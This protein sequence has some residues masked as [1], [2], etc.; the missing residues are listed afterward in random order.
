MGTARQRPPGEGESLRTVIIALLAN[1]GIAA[2]KF[3]AALLTRSSAML[4][5]A[6]H[7][8]ADTGNQVLLLLA[9]RLARRPADEAHPLGHGREAYFWALVAAL[10]MFLTGALLAVR[11]G[12]MELFHPVRVSSPLAAYVVLAVSFCLDGV[13]LT[14]A[15]RQLKKEATRLDLEF[16]EHFEL[17]SDPVGRAVFA[18]D[19]V[20]MVGNL[21]AFAG[22]VLDQ[23]TGSAIPDAVAALVI[24]VCLAVVALDLTRRNRDFLVGRQASARV[25][26]PLRQ[27]IARQPGVTAVDELWVTFVGPRRLW[28]VARIQTD[29]ALDGRA[30]KRLLRATESAVAGQSTSFERVDLVPS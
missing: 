15:Y 17:S 30:M 11:Q 21:V 24:G 5:E 26:D 7:A 22:I 14:R 27:L 25:R 9:D 23:L 6:I 3:V 19:A 4:A 8:T 13:S 20:A 29:D 1:A 18:E 2:A 28:V 10:G 12:I 16:L